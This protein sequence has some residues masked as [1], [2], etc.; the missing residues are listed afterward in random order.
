MTLGQKIREMRKKLGISQE[1]LGEI[2]NVSRQTITKWETDVGIPDES[3]LAEL[4]KLFGVPVDYFL[5][6]KSNSVTN[7]L[8]I[9]IIQKIYF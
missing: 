7:Q 9:N 2:V 5:S 1:V 8:D 3:N 4:A 6:S